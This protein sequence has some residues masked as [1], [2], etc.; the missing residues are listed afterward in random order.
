MKEICITCSLA[1]TLFTSLASCSKNDTTDAIID[2][3]ATNL[4][5]MKLTIGPRTFVA[6]FSN[7][8]AAAAFRKL[9]P[10]TL[11]MSELN[12]NEKLYDLPTALP[13]NASNPGTI[14]SGDIML[15]GEK[16]L[17]VF[18]K[19]FPTS[20]RYTRIARIA[21]V[22]GLAEAVGTGNVTI[23]FAD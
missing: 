9:L 15:Y 8:A 10:M 16:T 4:T 21:D 12:G 13:T 20:Y 3:T 23:S 6:A 2:T 14:T 7:T 11:N 18:Y 1:F 22:S 17:V 19:S 5:S